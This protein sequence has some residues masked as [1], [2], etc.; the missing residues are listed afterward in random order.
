MIQTVVFHP[1]VEGEVADAYHWYEQRRR[2]LGHAFLAACDL[3]Y[4]QLHSTLECGP[5]VYGDNV[6]RIILPRF[7]YVVYYRLTDRRAE[8]LAIQHGDI[9]P[10][11]L[12]QRA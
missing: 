1:A 4:E 12:Q 11:I 2:G 8:V 10:K 9:T 6:R 5:V 3:A 7:P